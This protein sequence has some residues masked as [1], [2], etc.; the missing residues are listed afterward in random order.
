MLNYFVFYY[1]IK[2]FNVKISPSVIMYLWLHIH[3]AIN[4]D[5]IMWMYK[6]YIVDM[7]N[8]VNN[9]LTH[10]LMLLLRWSGVYWVTVGVG[11]CDMLFRLKRILGW[12]HWSSAHRSISSVV[13]LAWRMTPSISFFLYYILLIIACYVPDFHIRVYYWECVMRTPR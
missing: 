3:S 1:T 11:L 5:V 7:L 2:S 6:Y 8:I 4:V 10:L 13:E 9:G 12:V